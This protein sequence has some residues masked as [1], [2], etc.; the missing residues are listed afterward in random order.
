MGKLTGLE[1]KADTESFHH[2]DHDDMSALALVLNA[3]SFII[4]NME[5]LWFKGPIAHYTGDVG[6]GFSVVIAFIA[7]NIIRRL[8]IRMR[9]RL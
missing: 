2:H 1:N 9:K 8:E 4:P 5:H 3:W 6:F 7:Y